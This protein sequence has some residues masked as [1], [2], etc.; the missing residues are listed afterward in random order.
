MLTAFPLV[1]KC[2]FFMYSLCILRGSDIVFSTK[3]VAVNV[4]FMHFVLR[5]G[6]FV[7]NKICQMTVF[8]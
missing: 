7:L 3:N 8:C 6:N 2:S 1:K 4:I 5:S